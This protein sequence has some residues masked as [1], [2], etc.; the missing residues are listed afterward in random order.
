MLLAVLGIVAGL[1]VLT[2]AADH[3]VI[4]AARLARRL[5]VST[6]VVGAVVI[7]FGTSAPELLVSGL[8]GAQGALD[9]A[10]G[11][12]VGSNIA[13]LTLVLGV[14]ALI[15]PIAVQSPALRREA[16][17]SLFAVVAFGIAVQGGVAVWEG[18]TLAAILVASLA[19]I[20]GTSRGGD[21][22]IAAEVSE[23]LTPAPVMVRREVLR[24]G[25]GLLATLGGAQLLVVS[26]TRAA[27]LLGW[28]E[29]FIGL[30]VV[31]VGTSLPELATAVQAARKQ[32]AGLV[33]GNLL[34][35]N[36]F[37]A[38][39]VGATAALAG[40]GQVAGATITG[41]GVWL[42][43]G[44]ATVATLFMVTGRRVVAWEGAALLM[45]YAATVPLLFG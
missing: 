31:A 12:I 18:L 3:F 4:G 15:T 21:D 36:L 1:A 11:N 17:L 28:S 43:I 6:I 39:G 38:A 25:V 44:V 8:A 32:E 5:R 26:A 24:T 42:M 14:A 2:V 41:L 16:P 10:V 37:N 20:I 27:E 9:L 45:L 33:V 13:N 35:S 23:F 7:G 29:S 40:A 34:G 30:T 22:P 19:V